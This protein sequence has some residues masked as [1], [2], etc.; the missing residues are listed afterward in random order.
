MSY[1]LLSFSFFDVSG[2]TS[3]IARTAWEDR[4]TE[5]SWSYD[6]VY[7]VSVITQVCLK[8]M[9]GTS[10]F[11]VPYEGLLPFNGKCTRSRCSTTNGP[12]QSSVNEVVPLWGDIPFIAFSV[13]AINRLSHGQKLLINFFIPAFQFVVSFFASDILTGISLRGSLVGRY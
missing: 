1:G 10:N 8:G 4:R 11:V 5:W 2:L 6:Q 3:L 7:S 12:G 9:P 13:V